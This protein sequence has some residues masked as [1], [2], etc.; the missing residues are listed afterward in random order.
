MHPGNGVEGVLTPQPHIVIMDGGGNRV[1]ESANV[2]VRARNSTGFEYAVGYFK[3][4]TGQMNFTNLQVIAPAP[5]S[6][7]LV[8]SINGR[9]VTINREHKLV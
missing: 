7:Q 5:S 1:Q 9:N 2:S 3:S 6:Y 8:F 4:N